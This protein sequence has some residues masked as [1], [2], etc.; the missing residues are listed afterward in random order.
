MT[1]ITKLATAKTG[2]LRKKRS[3]TM[4][5]SSLTDQ[6]VAYIEP[7]RQE[8][9]DVAIESAKAGDPGAI[10]QVLSYY[11][12]NKAP[13]QMLTIPGLAKAKTLQEKGD[14]ILKA[15]SK[16]SIGFEGAEKA[17]KILA[18]YATIVQASSFEE[19]LRALEQGKI[20]GEP[21]DI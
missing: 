5:T 15:L 20:Y 11:P 7:H 16:S 4:S 9:L 10:R 14:C 6:I 2:R 8:I 13:D 12:P 21:I 19:R 17:L 3:D 1:E 18:S